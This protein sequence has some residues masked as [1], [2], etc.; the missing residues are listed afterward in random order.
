YAQFEVAPDHFDSSPNQEV[1]KNETK[2]NAKVTLPAK[3]LVS[4][5]AAA[6]SNATST[7]L[8]K[9]TNPSATV[10]TSASLPKQATTPTSNAQ[11]AGCGS[12]GKRSARTLHRAKAA[13][14]ANQRQ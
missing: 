12:C 6:S 13:P 2:K 8:K 1:R 7:N 11:S 10:A 3:P 9:S 14:P 5:R 4:A